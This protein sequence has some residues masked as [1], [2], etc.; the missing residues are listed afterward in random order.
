MLVEDPVTGSANACIARV[1]QA[2]STAT[3]H[4]FNTAYRVRQGTVLQRDGRLSVTYLDGQ[5]WIGGH[6]VTIIDGQLRA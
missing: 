6:S 2:Q 1:L 4:R 5:P 3:G